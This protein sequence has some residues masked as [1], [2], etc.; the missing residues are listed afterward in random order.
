VQAEFLAAAS[1]QCVEVKPGE[2]TLIPFERMLLGVVAIVPDAVHGLALPIE[3]T[4]A[5]LNAIAIN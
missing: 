2:P 1:G 3:E 4:A 5:G